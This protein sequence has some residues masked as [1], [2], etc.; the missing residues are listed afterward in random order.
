MLD[1]SEILFMGIGKSP[2]CW[3]RCALPALAIGADWVGIASQPPGVQVVTGQVRGDSKLPNYDDYKVIIVQQVF[4]RAW[5]KQIHALKDRGIKVL[6]ET[7]DYLHG[8]AKQAGH[9]WA[10]DFTQRR[11]A[12]HESAMRVCDGIITTTDYIA[13]RYAKF[14]PNVYVCPNGVDVARYQLTRPH[15]AT[16][17]IGWAGGTGHAK[18]VLPWLGAM[19]GVMR[20]KE[21][22]CFVSI[23]EPKFATA[24]SQSLIPQRSLGIPFIPIECYPAAMTN[25]DIALAPAEK[26]TWFRGKSDLR[27]LEASALGIPTIAD[28]IVYPKIKHGVTGFHADTPEK[29]ADILTTLI[30]D[31]ALRDRVGQQA[32]EYVYSERTSDITAP[33][34]LEVCNAAVDGSDSLHQ[35]H[36]GAAL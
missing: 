28:P 3:Y 15:R 20:A 9:N 1:P 23:G 7:D 26:T 21:D 18:A 27:W 29:M 31:G 12:F 25:I 17:N 30:D 5:L 13:R 8:V 16:T 6:Y 35:L 34:W 32:R 11:L 36:R 22:T 14:N 10:S 24:V 2:V 4:G 19:V 33:A